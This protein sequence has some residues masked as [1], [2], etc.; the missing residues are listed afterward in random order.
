VTQTPTA[1][2]SRESCLELAKVFAIQRYRTDLPVRLL[3]MHDP[4]AFPDLVLI[5]LE[6]EFAFHAK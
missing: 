2:L 5:M 3:M 6:F 4:V 1:S